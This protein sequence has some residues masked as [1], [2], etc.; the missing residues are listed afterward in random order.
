MNTS[1]GARRASLS[2]LYAA[3]ASALSACVDYVPLRTSS[4][5]RMKP[6]EA[7]LTIRGDEKS[8]MR[9][10]SALMEQR[11]YTLTARHEAK[12]GRSYYQFGGPRM[13]VTRVQGNEYGVYS[14]TT[15]ISS[16]FFVRVDPAP[17]QTKLFLYGK[18]SMGAGSNGVCSD[19][20]AER[21]HDLGW[22]CW[23]DTT[24]LEDSPSWQFV[25]GA[26]EAEVV[27]GV[28]AAM[29]LASDEGQAA[30]PTLEIQNVGK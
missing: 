8:T 19:A 5:L 20:D 29:K 14:N 11:G 25:S 22:R 16:V 1:S 13:N 12:G 24:I 10:V 4:L 28:V 3:L 15:A 30:M 17:P 18:P 7:S 26:E 2:V 21:D 9:M 23:K 6:E 27:R